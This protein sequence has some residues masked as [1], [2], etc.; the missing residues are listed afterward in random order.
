MHLTQYLAPMFKDDP[1]VLIDLGARGGIEKKWI[2]YGDS[3]KAFCFDADEDECTR[4]NAASGPSIRYIP[5]VV[6]G[7][8]GNAT[9]YVTRLDASVGLYQT[10]Q[11]FFNRLLN[12]KNADLV[13]TRNVQVDTLDHIRQVYEIPAPD[14]I[15]LDVEGAELDIL[16]SSDLSE[17]FGFYSE[18][19]FHK[20]INGCPTF[21]DLDQFSVDKGFML[22]DMKFTRQSRKALPYRGPV[23][24]W[25]NGERFH[26]YTDSGQ[27]M[28]GDALYF[29]D[30]MRLKMTR[31][32]ILKAACLFE[33]FQLND[34]AA[35]L[36]MTQE[37]GLDVERC[38]DLLCGGSFA[39]YMANY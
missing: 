19:R 38:L 9:L 31:N 26:A 17:T 20:E 33:T 15:K 28:D 7:Y 3:L 1:L 4:L 25:A 29:R 36:L 18:F 23:M 5:E 35:E 37:A 8:A 32:Q 16:R 12:A 27:V 14:F 2:P 24:N 10:N 22:Y 21:S 6:A 13:S 11:K 30:P 39:T 34:C